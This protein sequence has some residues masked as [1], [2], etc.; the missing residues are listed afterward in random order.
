MTVFQTE[1]H[2]VTFIF[3]VL[4][5]LLFSHQLVFYLQKP[6][7]KQRKYYLI[8]LFLLIIYNIAGGLFPDDNLPLSI[9]LQFILAYGTGFCMGAYFPYY[10]YQ[11]F[12]IT[13]IEFHAKYG[14]LLFLILPFV[15]FFCILYPLGIPLMT[16]IYVG[17]VIPM[18]YAFYLMLL[19]LRGIR[20]RYKNEKTSL[21]AVLSYLAVCP[22]T[23]MPPMAYFQ[24]DQLT[25]VLLTNGGF[26]IITVLFIR[27]MIGE[28]RREFETLDLIQTKTPD[29]I[30]AF[31][32]LQYNLTNR[33]IEICELVR[34]GTNYKEIG[35]Q[36]YISQRTVN[37]HIQNIFKKT[38]SKNKVELLN[39]I[40]GR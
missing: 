5:S 25:E 8:L 33:E 24:V 39:T 14:V 18:L 38:N 28:S 17:L 32:C 19:I 27:K 11:A 10:F 13:N 21:D 1:I 2:I 23:F 3:I 6:A 40:S 37:K 31:Q 7:E 29:E 36:L 9:H 26:I 34:D 16:V 20:D 35:E 4:E 12:D 30:F 15:I 22:W